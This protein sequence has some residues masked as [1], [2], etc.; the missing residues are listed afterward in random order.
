[1]R[2]SKWEKAKLLGIY[3]VAEKSALRNVLEAVSECL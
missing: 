2:R 1:M 3:C